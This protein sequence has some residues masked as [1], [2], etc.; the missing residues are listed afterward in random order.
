M[1]E[2]AIQSIEKIIG[3]KTPS[4][5]LKEILTS[6]IITFA[7]KQE[8]YCV[9]IVDIVNST[10]ISAK[11]SASKIC[12]YYGI[13]LNN[14]ALIA[15]RHNA[16]VIKNIGDSLLFYFPDTNKGKD[17]IKFKETL[18][19]G[20]SMIGSRN[21][22]NELLIREDIPKVDFRVSM[23]FGPVAVAKIF[24]SANK[25]I[26]GPPVNICSKINHI[27]HSNGM[28]IGSDMYEMVK[29]ISGYRFRLISEF[30]N[31]LKLQ[32]PV[33]SVEKNM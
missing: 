19:C 12:K 13:F 15:R 27:A 22:I 14:M 25:D 4:N 1:N 5:H 3:Y 10:K 6:K 11:L 8:E 20:I 9:G 26:F 16:T 32:Y 31:G 33:F 17:E 2:N 30:S 18:D 24:D 21:Y 7:E 23:D 28:V 29:K